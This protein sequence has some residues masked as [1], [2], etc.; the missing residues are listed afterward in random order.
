VA[1]AA[2]LLRALQFASL[3]H[4]D[5]RRKD[6]DASPYINHPIAVAAVLAGEGR[7]TDDTLLLRRSFT[8]QLKIQR[9]CPKNLKN[10]S[11]RP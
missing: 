1:D 6:A 7:V 3:K 11:V 8:T 2:L 5:Q 4:R 10:C 9:Q